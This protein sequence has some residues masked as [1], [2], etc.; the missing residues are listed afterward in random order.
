MSARPRP[1]LV[2]DSDVLSFGPRGE[3]REAF[4]TS[5]RVHIDRWLPLLV[6]NCTDNPDDSLAR[7]V[8]VN[9][10]AY[11]IWSPA[12]RDEAES[13]LEAVLHRLHREVGRVLVIELHDEHQEQLAEDSPKLPSFDVAIGATG[14]KSGQ[15]ALNALKKSLGVMKVNFRNPDITIVDP[16]EPMLACDDECDRLTLTVPQVHRSPDGQLYPQV[17]HE[18]AAAFSESLLCAV[19]AFVGSVSDRTPPHHRALGRS[20]ILAAALKADKKLDTLA[21]SYD[22]LLSISPINTAEARDEFFAG[23]AQAEPDFR[24]RPL[25]VDP[26]TVKRDLYA[27]DLSVVEDLLLERILREKRREIDMQL[28]MLETRSTQAFRPASMML[29]GPVGGDLLAAAHNILDELKPAGIRTKSVEAHA[30]ADKAR[31]LIA[32]YRNADPRFQAKVEVR[33]DVSGLL[34]SGD[35]LMIASDTSISDHRLD[36]LLAHEVSV[37]LL[38]YFNGATQGMSIFRTGLAHYEGIQEGLGVFAEWAVGGLTVQRL[39][40][41]AG[42]VLAVEA[43]TKGATFVDVYRLLNGDCGFA[44]RSAFNI[45]ARVYRS[46]GLAKDAIYLKGFLEIIGRV[47]TGHSLEAFWL[48]KIAP[49]HV[50]AVD[51]LLERGLLHPPVFVP[52]FLGREGAQRRIDRLRHGETF[53]RLLELE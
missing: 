42:R 51:E 12:D 43:M 48:G 28:T 19:S 47:A 33:D 14:G 16:G 4:A 32:Y 10:P 21:R 29:Y 24:Y 30:I 46:G 38:T 44:R 36:P 6:L 39:R 7:Q 2:S 13:A 40:L 18:L 53:D 45:T 49:E 17:E 37:H 22:F 8:A 50:E 34:V 1:K 15:A 27:I 41:L 26:D 9:S 23:G 5:G 11:L 31:E 3:L 25:T 52:E 20:A 35:K